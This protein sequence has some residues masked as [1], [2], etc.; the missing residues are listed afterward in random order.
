MSMNAYNQLYDACEAHGFEM[1]VEYRD[2]LVFLVISHEDTGP[3]V[4]WAACNGSIE[5]TAKY[6]LAGLQMGQS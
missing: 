4:K 1:N 5:A 3:L 2:G 6:A